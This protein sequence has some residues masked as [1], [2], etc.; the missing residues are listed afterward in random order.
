MLWKWVLF[1]VFFMFSN[2]CLKWG[3]WLTQAKKI[4]TFCSMTSNMSVNTPKRAPVHQKS[5]V[6]KLGFDQHSYLYN[7]FIYHTALH[8]ITSPSTIPVWFPP[9]TENTKSPGEDHELPP[10]CRRFWFTLC[11]HPPV[12]PHSLWHSIPSN[13]NGPPGL[14]QSKGNCVSVDGLLPCR[15][16][17]RYKFT[18]QSA[19]EFTREF[20]RVQCWGHRF[21]FRFHADD[22]QLFLSI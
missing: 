10:P 13:P 1:K 8:H 7:N 9:K 5:I 15:Q 17:S 19:P 18:S 12:P 3:L 14:H 21:N 6:S 11:S 16:M 4:F 2:R 20:L 22:A